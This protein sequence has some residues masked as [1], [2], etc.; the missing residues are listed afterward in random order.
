MCKQAKERFVLDLTKSLNELIDE[1]ESI[2]VKE[3]NR[4]N[5]TIKTAINIT[6]EG[7]NFSKVV[8]YID[9]FYEEYCEGST[10]ETITQAIL[11]KI[12][13]GKNQ[14]QDKCKLLIEGIYDYEQIKDALIVKL[15]NLEKNKEY[16]KD[17]IYTKMLDLAICLY[18]MVEDGTEEIATVAIPKKA[19]EEWGKNKEEVIKEAIKNCEKV[20]PAGIKSMDEIII[21][22]I[23]DADDEDS[24]IGQMNPPTASNLW[25]LTNDKKIN[26]AAAVLYKGVLRKF[27]EDNKVEEVYVVPSSIHEVILVPITEECD[28]TVE[29]LNEMIVAVNDEQVAPDEILGTHAYIYNKANDDIYFVEK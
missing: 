15:I 7:N 16:L 28:M 25:V 12:H 4:N 9:S 11:E 27:A 3:V 14:V 5:D 17:K 24:F 2:S 10:I 26:G 18:A 22:I 19:L 23:L 6:K 13:T 1:K 21:D 29:N 20:L 8:L